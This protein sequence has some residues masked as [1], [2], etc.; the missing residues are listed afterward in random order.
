MQDMFMIS[1]EDGTS[2]AVSDLPA[3]QLPIIIYELRRGLCL[4]VATNKTPEQAIARIE[5]EILRRELGL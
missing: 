5:I 3:E 1:A 2:I 4:P